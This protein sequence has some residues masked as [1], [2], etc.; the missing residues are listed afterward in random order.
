V[1]LYRNAG[2]RPMMTL[3][4]DFVPAGSPDD[5]LRMIEQGRVDVRRAPVI[6]SPAR[7]LRLRLA[8][9]ATN[10]DARVSYQFAMNRAGAL[11]RS[12][13]PVILSYSQT[14]ASGWRLAID[15]KRAE[16]LRVN[17]LF[18][19]AFV[20]A[21]EHRVTWSYRT[22][23]LAAGATISILSLL[24]TVTFVLVARRRTAA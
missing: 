4:R 2:A 3:S 18:L 16:S 7:D 19:G 21:G 1:N 10:F 22:P 20:P 6:S 23:Y 11:V 14:A 8:G 13:Q 12:T 5:A 24:A 15:G 9:T 17:G